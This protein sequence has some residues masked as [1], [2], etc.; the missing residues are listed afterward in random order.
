MP[1]RGTL[2]GSQLPETRGTVQ[3]FMLTR[4][5]ELDGIILADGTEPGCAS[6]GGMNEPS[7]QKKVASSRDASQ[8]EF[9]S[10][11]HRNIALLISGPQRRSSNRLGVG[12]VKKPVPLRT[13]RRKWHASVTPVAAARAASGRANQQRNIPVR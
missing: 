2:Y 5:S 1:P 9:P 3:R 8:T 4:M 7:R 12:G 13:H 6:T 10:I 11:P